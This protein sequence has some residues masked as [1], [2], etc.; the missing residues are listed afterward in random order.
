MSKIKLNAEDK[1][2]LF[3]LIT[4]TVRAI[5]NLFKRKKNGIQSSESN[6]NNS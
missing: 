3:P 6:N 1:A 2:W 4:E 5:I